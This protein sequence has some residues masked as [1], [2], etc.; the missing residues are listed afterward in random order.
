MCRRVVKNHVSLKWGFNKR[1]DM[2]ECRIISAYLKQMLQIHEI[3]PLRTDPLWVTKI[4]YEWV[5]WERDDGTD[6]QRDIIYYAERIE[7]DKEKWDI[8]TENYERA[9]AELRK[10]YPKM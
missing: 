8:S 5:Q 6:T 2:S 9:L 3:C 1:N 10:R 7:P 4:L